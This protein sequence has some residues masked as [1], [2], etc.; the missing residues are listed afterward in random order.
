MI[1]LFRNKSLITKMLIAPS[2]GV[3]SFLLFILHLHNGFDKAQTSI[4]ELE[5]IFQPSLER[6]LNN[7]VL[8]ENIVE[9]LN[10]AVSAAQPE[11]ID[12]IDSKRDIILFNLDSIKNNNIVSL[13]QIET[14]EE[15]FVIYVTLSK[16]VSKVLINDDSYESLQDDLDKMIHLFS[17]NNELLENVKNS[18]KDH[19]TQKIIEIKDHLYNSLIEGLVLV[20]LSV[21]IMILLLVFIG[22]NIKS[23]LTFLQK[24]LEQLL[25]GSFS[26]KNRIDHKSADEI[27]NLVN[28]FNRLLDKLE[29]DHQLLLNAKKRFEN[30]ANE[31]NEKNT[32]ILSLLNNANDGFLYI[33]KQGIIGDSHSLKCNDFFN[34]IISGEHIENVFKF[35]NESDK[36]TLLEGI[37]NAF[38]EEDSDISNIYLSLIPKKMNINNRILLNDYKKI[39]DNNIM[40]IIEDI[41]HEAA[42]EKSLENER[43]KLK[44][45]INVATNKL[46][47]IETLQNF[48]LYLKQIDDVSMLKKDQFLKKIPHMYLQTHTYKGIF[49]QFDFL[50]LPN[51]LHELEQ[52]ISNCSKKESNDI[53]IYGMTVRISNIYDAYSED[54]KTIKDIFGHDYLSKGNTIEVPV[55]TITSI[56]NK[57]IGL[58]SQIHDQNAYYKS[59]SSILNEIQDLRKTDLIN[60]LM[61][62]RNMI[63][64]LAKKLNKKIEQPVFNG[65]KAL[66]HP[67][68]FHPFIKSL[69]HVFRNAI[70]HGIEESHVR[71]ENGKN[72]TANIACTVVKKPEG[73]NIII[74][75]DGRGI[76]TS[77]LR[78]SLVKKEILSE[79]IALSL[80]DEE[81]VYYIFE[82]NLTT[83]HSVGE[84]SGR[85]IGLSAVKEE[86]DK[87][88]GSVKIETEENKFTRFIFKFDEKFL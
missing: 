17:R 13:E 76:Q 45:A 39:N 72:K 73:F 12:E 44:M 81:L 11:W 67:Q 52:A 23:N 5:T 75:D 54:L 78:Q 20:T 30:I 80:S 4:N 79:E 36:T 8:F 7:I 58:S 51:T 87:L 3:F 9:T 22:R 60:M 18:I 83:R 14:L 42:L 66:V 29:V 25:D 86:L 61:P 70:D 74:E 38:S 16:N 69:V 1:N 49:S 46:D 53:C 28:Y 21:I 2:I 32:E 34:K 10:S 71:L 84:L 43:K 15:N 63:E 47:V 27:G 35:E 37:K 57:M 48:D 77:E 24:Y 64:K 82:E 26:F 65:D 88:S 62:Y 6:A 19:H 40:I 41:T 55:D 59:H 68:Q 33:D 31:L 50:L 56:E 85:G